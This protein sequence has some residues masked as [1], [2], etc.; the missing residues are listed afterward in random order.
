MAR[1]NRTNWTPYS[2]ATLVDL[3]GKGFTRKQIADRLQRS[4]KAVE[5]KQ[6]SI[7]YAYLQTLTFGQL[8]RLVNGQA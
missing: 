8:V 2:T 7:K 6:H 5:R 1:Q 4:Q 3:S